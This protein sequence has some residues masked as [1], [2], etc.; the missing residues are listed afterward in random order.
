MLKYH[1]TNLTLSEKGAD[2]ILDKANYRS[3]RRQ[4]L[5]RNEET[6]NSVVKGPKKLIQ[7]TVLLV[8]VIVI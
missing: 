4:R 1:K 6:T 5:L 3:S 7:A 2:E 8:M